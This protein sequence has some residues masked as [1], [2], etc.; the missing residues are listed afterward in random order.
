MSGQ[1]LQA[2]RMVARR[3][4]EPDEY[5]RARVARNECYI[6]RYGKRRP[7]RM[8]NHHE[9]ASTRFLCKT[10]GQE[11]STPEDL[12]AHWRAVHPEVFSESWRRQ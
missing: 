1:A 5:E 2:I 6:R 4:I 10:C 9:T 8:R 12:G 11:Y 7:G 3:G